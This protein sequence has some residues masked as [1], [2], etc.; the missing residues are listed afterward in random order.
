[1]QGFTVVFPLEFSPATQQ[2]V[3]V[4][5]KATFAAL[6]QQCTTPHA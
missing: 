6:R 4:A 1:M 3:V 5:A 2:L